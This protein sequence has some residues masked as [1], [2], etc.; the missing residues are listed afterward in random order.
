MVMMRSEEAGERRALGCRDSPQNGLD[1][2]PGGRRS[3][4][5]PREIA[6]KPERRR[7]S[8]RECAKLTATTRE[9]RAEGCVETARGEELPLSR[10]EPR[11]A[12]PDE[13][14]ISRHAV[15]RGQRGGQREDGPQAQPGCP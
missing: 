11:S 3:S 2:A 13:R 1:P 12:E 8:D 15:A 6:G 7:A 9:D 14:A 4:P 10:G 5:R